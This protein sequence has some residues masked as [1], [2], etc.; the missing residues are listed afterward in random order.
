MKSGFRPRDIRGRTLAYL[1][2]FG[3]KGFLSEDSARISDWARNI[4]KL[5]KILSK[6]NDPLWLDLVKLC[7]QI[8]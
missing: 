2:S 7:V 8:A 4:V 1:D 6:T 3:S 5:N